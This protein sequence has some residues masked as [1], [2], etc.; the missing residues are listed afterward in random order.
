LETGGIVASLWARK[1]EFVANGTAEQ[2][3]TAVHPG[4]WTC[5][6]GDAERDFL[7]VAHVIARIL[8]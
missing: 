4:V 8:V 1:E 3:G 5:D 6:A 2:L 7:D